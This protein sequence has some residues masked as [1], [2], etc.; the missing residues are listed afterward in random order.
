MKKFKE[1]NLIGPE[2]NF[3]IKSIDFIENGKTYGT[4]ICPL[5]NNTFQWYLSDINRGKKKNCGCKKNYHFNDITNQEFNNLLVLERAQRDNVVNNHCQRALWLVKCQ[6][7]EQI[8][9]MDLHSLKR[10]DHQPCPN[11]RGS[12]SK[13]E[14]KII[15]LLQ[16]LNISFETQKTFNTCRFLDTNAMAKFDFYLP[17][18]NL[19]IEFNG[20]QHYFFTNSGWN[21]EETFNITTSHDEY[22]RQWCNKNNIRLVIIPYTD[23]SI[24]NKEYI[25]NIL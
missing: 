3:L 17:Q 18:Q 2:Q 6:D 1:N 19:L 13:G 10:G 22:K 14:T 21:T 7:C 4:V 15:Q 12:F 9:K 24:L 20:E 16:E 25:L 23:L 5:C 8:L 11:I